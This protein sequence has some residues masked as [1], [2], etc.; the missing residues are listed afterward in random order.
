M[1]PS[2]FG[3]HRPVS[4]SEAVDL[5][6]R[7]QDEDVKILAGGQSL[8]PL[9]NFRLSVPGHLVDV[10][11]VPELAGVRTDGDTLRLGAVVR[12]HEL[13]ESPVV[14]AAGPL[15]AAAAPYVG[16]PQIRTMGT[17][18]G[19]LAHADPAAELPGVV[20]ALDGRIVI[21]SVRGER[22]VAAADFFRSHFTTALEPDELIVAIE[23]PVP[24]ARSGHAFTE[25]AARYGDFALAGAGAAVT[26]DED[27]AITAARIALTSV[28]PTPVRAP[29]AEELLRGRTPDEGLLTE[30]ARLVAAALDPA[31]ELKASAGYKR[32]TAGVL[33][34]RAV[35]QAWRRAVGGAPAEPRPSDTDE[36]GRA[37]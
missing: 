12:H 8:V 33:A 16:H 26:V 22:T 2:A 5:L 4:V 36:K 21:R 31:P 13:L 18:G 28:A 3:Y 24:P 23:L 29:D 30:L 35:H 15:L 19:S 34:G 6:E 20:L 37:A 32:R 27:G 9:M 17:L 11:A 14:R 25:V 7:L 1:K 10:T